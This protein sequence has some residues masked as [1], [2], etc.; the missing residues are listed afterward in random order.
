MEDAVPDLVGGQVAEE[1]FDPVEPRDRGGRKVHLESPMHI[2]PAMDPGMVVGR[3]VLAD[4]V[5]LLARR[6]KSL[7]TS[8]RARRLTATQ[9]SISPMPA[10]PR[11]TKGPTR[12]EPTLSFLLGAD[13]IHHRTLRIVQSPRDPNREDQPSVLRVGPFEHPRKRADEKTL[14]CLDRGVALVVEPT[15]QFVNAS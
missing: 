5:S 12:M 1:D 10:T 2:D 7:S 15:I 4:H 6:P 9:T 13:S 3:I 11:S 14:L 8:R